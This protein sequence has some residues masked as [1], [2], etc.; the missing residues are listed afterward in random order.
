MAL[1][2]RN[3]DELT[4]PLKSPVLTIGNFDGVHKGH[5]A[6]FEKV[7]SRAAFLGGD[8]V[9]MTF[10]P[11]P[12]RV[13]K[14]GS[15]PPSITPT[16]LKLELIEAAGIRVI[17][18]LPF[19]KSFAEISAER[20]IEDILVGRIGIKEIV[21]GY[22]YSFGRGR[23]GDADFLRREGERLG[24]KVHQLGQVYVE[25][26]PVS[27]TAIR[28]LVK[29]GLIPEANELL[30]SP[31]TIE[32]TV[33]R[34]RS[35]GA[36]LLSFPTANLR[37]EAELIPGPGV[38]AVR[39]SIEGKIHQGVTN[40]GFNPTFGNTSLSIETH[41]INFSGNLQG[42]SIRLIFVA[43]LRDERRFP[44]VEAL[45]QCIS[46]DIEAARSVLD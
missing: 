35:R 14:P 11:H 33:V 46:R 8:S 24:F 4:T 5:L 34:G 3:L 19:S 12:L 36:A 30:G 41:I 15:A 9:V 43:R 6:L 40:I 10:D 37:T 28:S 29:Q 13:M 17:V 22:D 25:D 45:S 44:S 1:I 7:R 27:S 39:V 31:F 2:I 16:G 18:C 38:Y 26:A 32:G 21:T 23:E 20:F 42:A